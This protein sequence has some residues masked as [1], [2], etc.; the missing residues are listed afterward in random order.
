MSS[1]EQSFGTPFVDIVAYPQRRPPVLHDD[2]KTLPFSD[3]FLSQGIPV[4]IKKPTDTDKLNEKWRPAAIEL[5]RPSMHHNRS[6]VL[7]VPSPEEKSTMKPVQVI[8]ADPLGNWY[9]EVNAKGNVL[10]NP[11]GRVTVTDMNPHGTIDAWGLY[12]KELLPRAIHAS[13]VFREH[14]ID[15]E[16]IFLA[17]EMR[18]F[19]HPQKDETTTLKHI[20]AFAKRKAVSYGLD[21]ITPQAREAFDDIEFVSLLR[22]VK[23]SYRLN[24]IAYVMRTSSAD[25]IRSFFTHLISLQTFDAQRRIK[26]NDADPDVHI[27]LKPHELERYLTEILPKRIALNIARMHNAGIVHRFLHIGNVSL[28]GEI[29]DLDSPVGKTIDPQDP[30][31]SGVHDFAVDLWHFMSYTNLSQII[32]PIVQNHPDKNLFDPTQPNLER[33]FAQ[34]FIVEYA[35][36]RNVK[37][38]SIEYLQL[39]LMRTALFAKSNSREVGPYPIPPELQA[40][41]DEGGALA[42]PALIQESVDTYRKLNKI[43]RPRSG[44]DS[45]AE[46]MKIVGLIEHKVIE[47]IA[48]QIANQPSTVLESIRKKM[49]REKIPQSEIVHVMFLHYQALIYSYIDFLEKHIREKSEHHI[50]DVYERDRVIRI[51][52]NGIMLRFGVVG[53]NAFKKVLMPSVIKNKEESSFKVP[54][55]IQPML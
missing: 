19:L 45:A 38:G 29:M 7:S 50:S 30:H 4:L 39:K 33:I 1:K 26:R 2:T 14:G 32:G 9:A 6:F 47:T 13:Q 21:Q 48:Q 8:F 46:T 36:V 53:Y 15:A 34:S 10:T 11:H 41:F 42:D 37:P 20:R 31:I 54:L 49:K 27:S 35:K 17:E 23:T 43:I 44:T 16:Y 51:M 28:L 5:K 52:R 22:G 18:Q 24:D 40:L 55:L 12:N 3:Q 25:D